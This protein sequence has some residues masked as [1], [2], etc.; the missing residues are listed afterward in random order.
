M[1]LAEAG[2]L[3]APLDRIADEVMF[4]GQH[5]QAYI[6]AL[7][8]G[9]L[10]ELWRKDA[11]SAGRDSG[12]SFHQRTKLLRF[13]KQHVTEGIT[14]VDLADVLDLSSDY[15]SRRFAT[16]FGC[17]PRI[18]LVRRRMDVAADLLARSNLTIYQIAERMGYA[19]PAQFSRQFKATKG[20]SPRQFRQH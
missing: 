14:P 4:D 18:W 3:K 1:V 15:F 17:S 10:I 9:L 11:R 2:D 13:T 19:E 5:T 20:L 12:F 8:T 7:T 6:R 16:T